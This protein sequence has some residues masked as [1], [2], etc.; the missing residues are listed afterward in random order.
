MRPPIAMVVLVLAG[1]ALPGCERD[2]QD[3]PEGALAQ[4]VAAMNASRSDISARRRAYELLSD[5]ARASLG[6]RAARASQLSGRD[7]QPWEMLA[8]GRF[9]LHI[10]FDPEALVATT[11]GDHAIIVARGRA[12]DRAEV[13]MV[14]EAGHWRVDLTLPPMRAVQTDRD[15]GV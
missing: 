10:P 9:T 11:T 1:L 5:P 6:E 7:I 3:S 8:P 14:R 13:P 4:W 15:G 2:P 12:G